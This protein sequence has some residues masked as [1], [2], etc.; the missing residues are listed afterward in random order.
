MKYNTGNIYDD[1]ILIISDIIIGFG[2]VLLII[3]HL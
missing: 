3:I 1:M 2:V